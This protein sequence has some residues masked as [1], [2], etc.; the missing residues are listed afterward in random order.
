MNCMIL[1]KEYCGRRKAIKTVKRKAPFCANCIKINLHFLCLN[2]I[3]QNAKRKV[4]LLLL[5]E[6]ASERTK[7]IFQ[8]EGKEKN[9]PVQECLTSEEI[10]RRIGKSKKAIIGISDENFA[11]AIYKI[12]SGGEAIG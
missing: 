6:D 1:Q 10:G 8:K 4:K 12:L 5:A 7:E 9:I 3:A 11:K 2:Q